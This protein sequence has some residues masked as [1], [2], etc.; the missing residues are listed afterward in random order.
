M[1]LNKQYKL[2]DLDNNEVVMTLQTVF[3]RYVDKNRI[4]MAWESLGE[5][6]GTVSDDSSTRFVIR[7]HG[8]GSVLPFPD[9]K[10]RSSVS[11]LRASTIVEP[12]VIGSA[13]LADQSHHRKQAQLLSDAVAPTH[14]MAFA[15]RM[16]QL[17]NMLLD[18]SIRSSHHQ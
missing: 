3:R 18:H 11:T 9:S 1:F 2:R 12:D 15:A 17:E 16:Q 13:S 5:W 10:T 6:P 4:Y 7:E 8:W 14:Q